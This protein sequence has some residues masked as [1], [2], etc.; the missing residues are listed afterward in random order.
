[1]ENPKPKPI[2]MENLN[3]KRIFINYISVLERVFSRRRINIDGKIAH[4]VKF[5]KPFEVYVFQNP[6]S[7]SSSVSYT[8][9]NGEIEE[10]INKTGTFATFDNF[11]SPRFIPPSEGEER[12]E[13]VRGKFV[14]GR[15]PWSEASTTCVSITTSRTRVPMKS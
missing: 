11:Y 6:P 9:G 3:D 15:W 13:M 1:M 7:S 14:V 5:S 12:R 2:S 4:S 8:N 10:K